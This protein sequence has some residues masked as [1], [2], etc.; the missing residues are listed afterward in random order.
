METPDVGRER[1]KKSTQITQNFNCCTII[2]MIP[3]TNLLVPLKLPM[4][5]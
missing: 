3:L 4:G 1:S 5:S 2:K